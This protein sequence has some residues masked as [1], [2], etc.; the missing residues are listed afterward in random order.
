MKLLEI[1]KEARR[2]PE[3]NKKVSTIDQLLAIKEKHGTDNIFVTFTQI[4]KLGANPRSEYDTPIGI[5][6]YPLQYVINNS[7][8][9]VPFAG[10]SPYIIVF[11]NN[12]S[13]T[14]TLN[15]TNIPTNIK[16]SI[17][18]VMDKLGYNVSKLE[19]QK[20][21]IKFW[22]QIYNIVTN[23]ASIN[24]RKIFRMS[25][26]TGIIDPGLGIIHENEYTQAVFFDTKTLSHIATIDNTVG[27]TP[28]LRSIKEFLKN[29]EYDNAIELSIELGIRISRLEPIL[30]KQSD[31]NSAIMYA[32]ICIKGRWPEL[33]TI[34][35]KSNDI[36]KCIYYASYMMD[37]KIWP[38]LETIIIEL[39]DLNYILDYI[40]R[41][42]KYRWPEAEHI[43]K[44]NRIYWNQYSTQFLK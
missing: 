4:P 39:G 12:S 14:W 41:V 21:T 10:N 35:I 15:L 36:K 24:V 8:V 19:N 6:S 13:K 32:Y 23:N 5:Y 44:S 27:I 16:Q 42:R 43:I 1:I 18:Q 26:L 11:K 30:L 3:Q 2:N 22:H 31:L 29:K 25:G 37:G 34:L 20:T 40:N 9:D 28:K 17:I 38:E 33:E 7:I